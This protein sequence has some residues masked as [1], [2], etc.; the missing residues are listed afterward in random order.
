MRVC[1]ALVFCENCLSLCIYTITQNT[2]I[3]KQINQMYN[4][5]KTDI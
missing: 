1:T 4:I 2:Y 5:C 3:V